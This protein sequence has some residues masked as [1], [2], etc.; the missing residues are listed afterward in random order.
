[1][2]GAPDL[3]EDKPPLFLLLCPQQVA[4]SPGSTQVRKADM[5]VR[6]SGFDAQLYHSIPEYDPKLFT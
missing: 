5:D 1:M 3:Y 6:L 4:C 2:T